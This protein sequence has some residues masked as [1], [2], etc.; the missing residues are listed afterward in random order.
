MTNFPD[1][2]EALSFDTIFSEMLADLQNRDEVFNALAPSDPAYQILAVCAYRELNIRQRVN[3]SAR[4]TMLTFAT[5]NDLDAIGDT[6]RLPRKVIDRGD[7]DAVP[8]IPPTM[9]SDDVYRARLQLSPEGFTVAGPKNS[10]KY[11]AVNADDDVKDCGVS[12]PSAGTVSLSVLAYSGPASTDLVAKVLAACNAEETR[13]L[14]DKVTAAPCALV[15]ADTIAALHVGLEPESD[16][17]VARAT[18][19][20]AEYMEG[21]RLVGKAVPISGIYKALMVA[22]VN[23][24]DLTSPTSD[25]PAIADSAYTA[26][27]VSLTTIIDEVSG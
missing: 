26:G 12:S 10:Y 2:V 13:P 20:L 3:D 4:A 6:Y 18:E 27:V 15:A 5:G 11:F 24:V 25:L 19:S 8:P 21:R 17:T 7:P 1:V 16:D 9:E 22:G 14:T 23:S